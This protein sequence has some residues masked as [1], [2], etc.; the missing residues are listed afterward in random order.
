MR[1]TLFVLAL[2]L[3]GSSMACAGSGAAAAGE[4]GG[5]EAAMGTARGGGRGDSAGGGLRSPGGQHVVAV[6]R[7]GVYVDGRRVHASGGDVQVLT[8][9]IWRADGNAVAW[10]ER[11]RGDGETRLVVVSQVGR[12]GAEPMVW[13]LPRI[14]DQDRVHWSG[15]TKVVVGPSLLEP[16]AVA[17]WSEQQ[18][19]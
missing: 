6:S 10:T 4:A 12:G 13:P 8:A 2:G 11:G 18:V 16:R 7:G 15:L 19:R 1:S 17:N 9:P 5:G 3:L 14:A